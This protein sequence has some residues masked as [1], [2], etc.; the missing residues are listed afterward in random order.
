[1]G[2]VVNYYPH[3]IG[4]YLTATTH[5][6]LLEH[7]V[8]RRLI[9]VYY[10]REAPLPADKNQVYRLVG[11]RTKEEKEAVDSI[12]SEF[13]Q[14]TEE[15]WAQDRCD[16]EIGLCNK[17]RTNGKKGG[18]PSKTKNPDKTQAEPRQNPNGTQ[19]E[20]PPS[21]H[22]PITPTT[23]TASA[24]AE[25]EFEEAWR[26]F[27][28]RAGGNPKG[29][30]LKAWRARR[31]EGATA[32]EIQEGVARYAAFVRAT[33]REHTEFVMQSATFFGPDRQFA[34][35]WNPPQEKQRPADWWASDAATEAKGKELGLTPRAG[36][37]WPQFKDR[38]RAKL[39]ERMAA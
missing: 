24:E 18:R 11:A 22:Y 23:T 20:S 28:K 16:Y 33:G 13:F 17:N 15:G 31:K 6:T 30:A 9:D 29:R 38:I 8:Y 10:I 21:P 19:P 14:V 36:E 32:A 34:E 2:G 3:H 1:M 5:L 25:P 37:G 35:P 7:G 4:D 39:G 27:P 12:L 26:L